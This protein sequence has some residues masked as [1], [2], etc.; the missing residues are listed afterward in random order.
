[1]CNVSL[2]AYRARGGQQSVCNVSLT[3]YRARGGQQSVCNV[4]LTAYRAR[5]GQQS[6][7]VKDMEQ[8]WFL[9]LTALLF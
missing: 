9:I 5:G 4:S 8:R 6:A 2:T 7:S 1:M 3:A